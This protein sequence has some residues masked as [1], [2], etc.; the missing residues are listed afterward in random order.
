VSPDGPLARLP[1]PLL[2]E[3][4]LGPDGG[5]VLTPSATTWFAL[6]PQTA[7]TGRHRLAL[8]DPAYGEGLE[9]VA[10]RVFAG[11]RPLAPLPGTGDEVRAVTGDGD[12][13]LLGADA[14]E[15]NLR[16]AIA[17]AER[18]SAIHL[19]CHGLPSA[20]DPSLS[21]L[22]FT[23]T[24]TEDGFFTA[25]EVYSQ[26]VNADLVVLSA[27][28]SGADAARSGEGLAGLTRAFLLAGAPRVLASVARVDDE[29]TRHFM[30]AFYE[31]WAKPE[32]RSD[33]ALRRARE[34]VRKSRPHPSAWGAFV[35]WGV[36]D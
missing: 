3:C 22:A 31:E 26:F 21:A 33:E 17:R 24:E 35:L 1:W 11:T 8:G 4:A 9:D 36:P 14:T 20:R 2:A 5:A 32:S 15:G 34:K 12:V 18:W 25:L 16:R 13:R 19:A 30:Q 10:R 28:E 6:R 7:R 29:A 23:P 27:C